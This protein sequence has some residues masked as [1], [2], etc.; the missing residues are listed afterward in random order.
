MYFTGVPVMDFR[1]AVQLLIAL[2]LASLT[3]YM[4]SV[5]MNWVRMYLKR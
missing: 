3:V 2:V 4:H 1:Y 5:G